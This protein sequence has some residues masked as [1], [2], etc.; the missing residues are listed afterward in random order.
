MKE[1]LGKETNI[2]RF[3]DEYVSY[4]V[5]SKGDGVYSFLYNLPKRVADKD[6]PVNSSMQAKVKEFLMAGNLYYEYCGIIKL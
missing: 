3:A 4:P 5:D 6:L 1:I 2:T